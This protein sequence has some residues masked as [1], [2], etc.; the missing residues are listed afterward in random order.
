[1]KR[2]FIVSSIVVFLMAIIVW[3]SASNLPTHPIQEHKAEAPQRGPEFSRFALDQRRPVEIDVDAEGFAGLSKRQIRDQLRDWMLYVVVADSGTTAEEVRQVLYDL[4]PMRR[5]YLTAVANYDYGMSRSRVIGEDALALIPAGEGA[6]Q[7]RDYIAEIADEY[8]KNTGKPPQSVAVF[9]YEMEESGKQAWITR[10]AS[11][12]GAEAFSEA[13]G[14]TERKVSSRADLVRFIAATDDLLSVRLVGDSVIIAGRKLQGG[15]YASVNLDDVAAILQS[16][17][18]ATANGGGSGF[19][20]D[21]EY[22]YDTLKAYFD[23]AKPLLAVF[24]TGEDAPFS[25][26][27]ISAIEEAIDRKDAIPFLQL[28]EKLKGIPDLGAARSAG[29][30]QTIDTRSQH[31][32]ARYDGKLKGTE[33][34][35]TLFYTDL[36]AK[37]WA[38]DYLKSAPGQSIEDFVPLLRVSTAAIY[39]KES[40]RLSSTRLWFG[41]Q[42]RGFQTTADAVR[43]SRTAT[44]VYAASSNPAEPGKEAEPNAESSAFLGWWNDHYDDVARFEPQYQRL[45]EIMKW[46]VLVGWLNQHNQ[47]EQFHYLKDVPVRRD[48]WFNDWVK[49]RPELRYRRWTNVGFYPRGYHDSKTETMPLLVSWR[50]DQVRGLSGGVSLG[51]RESVAARAILK[52]DVPLLARR[53]N[54]DY[55]SVSE[56]ELLTLE[57]TSYKFEDLTSGMESRVVAQAKETAKFRDPGIELQRVSFGMT[58]RREGGTFV[59]DASAGGRPLGSVSIEARGNAFRVGFKSLD[60]ERVGHLAQSIADRGLTG[61]AAETALLDSNKFRAVV[62]VGK[63]HYLVQL[64]DSSRW[65]EMEAGEL[66]E[67]ASTAMRA[68]GP[69]SSSQWNINWKEASDLK[70]NLGEGEYV[71]MR[72]AEK[73]RAVAVDLTTRGPPPPGATS[74]EVR[75]GGESITALRDPSNGLLYVKRAEL[76]GVFEKLSRNNDDVASF[77]RVAERFSER[78]Y[79]P[80]ADEIAAD[81]LRFKN[82]LDAERTRAYELAANDL[83]EGRVVEAAHRVEGAKQIF[84]IDADQSLL[85]S[86]TEL[87]SDDVPSAARTAAQTAGPLRGESA[88]FNA[89]EKRLGATGIAAEQRQNLSK[90]ADFAYGRTHGGGAFDLVPDLTHGRFDLTAHL[91]GEVKRADVLPVDL[92]RRVVYVEVGSRLD[93][94]AMSLGQAADEVGTNPKL[95]SAFEVRSK[96]LARVHPATVTVNGRTYRL[97]T[98]SVTRGANRHCY[99][100]IDDGG[101]KDQVVLLGQNG[102]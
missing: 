55:A 61:E 74:S 32:S 18:V 45:N 99:G 81:P 84:G 101:C 91:L 43:F 16:E 82:T 48:L 90:L 54:L 69:G 64:R 62:R 36:L 97:V 92:P 77:N 85:K 10:R 83:A 58:F 102:A 68:G 14:Y 60:T 2:L 50:E 17:Q 22:E 9:E 71:V 75:L 23:K 57:K 3:P 72:S 30:L 24:A 73:S 28:L 46:S 11:V 29:L 27:E 20:L 59:A 51:S 67:N 96:A 1:M 13:Y 4:P 6:A 37:L 21:P 98:D 39:A 44:R 26:A 93:Q 89:I 53:A 33:V 66:T 87:L 56:H 42:D 65:A 52:D 19:S 7:R 5:G 12:P 31:Q 94:P 70:G 15:N 88:F 38:L 34:G 76:P 49:T 8:M 100:A 95:I 80:V 41:P 63:D 47:L 40:D 86:M 78:N 25:A 35:M 79:G